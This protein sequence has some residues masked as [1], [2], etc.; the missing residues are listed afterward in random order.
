MCNSTGLVKMHL[1]KSP[2]VD[3]CYTLYKCDT[4][5]SLQFDINENSAVSIEEF[6]N[7]MAEEKE[8]K[9]IHFSFSPYWKR[10]VKV[11]KQLLGREPESILDVGCRT[12]DFLLHWQEQTKRVGI[13][14]ASMAAKIA[15]DRGLIVYQG[16]VESIELSEQFDIVS[17]YAVLEH[18]ANPREVLNK[19]AERVTPNGILVILIPCFQTFK[20]NL[21]MALNIRWHMYCPPEHLNFFSRSYLDTF[22]NSKGLYLKKRIYTSGGMFNPFRNVSGIGRIFAKGM[23][24]MD[25]FSP[26]NHFPIFDHM[27]SYY[28]K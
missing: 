22:L 13:E 26:L 12:G 7:K 27:Y 3:Q 10:E 20:A 9:N 4:C 14:I 5:G 21:L 11:I 25:A 1:I 6:Y 28:M 23:F 17:C 2:L 19:L 16:P 8:N 15:R 18:S 24:I